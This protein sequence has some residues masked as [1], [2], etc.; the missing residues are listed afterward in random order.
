MCKLKGQMDKGG[1]YDVEMK[2]WMGKEGNMM[3][4]LKSLMD[5]GVHYD[6][7]MK[8]WMQKRGIIRCNL[9]RGRWIREVIIRLK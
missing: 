1:H 5:K 3:C 6:V 9:K 4:K 7:E 8:W 2:G